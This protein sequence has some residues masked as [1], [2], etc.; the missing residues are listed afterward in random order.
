[1]NCGDP[2]LTLI[3]PLKSPELLN[4]ILFDLGNV[5]LDIDFDRTISAFRSLGATDFHVDLDGNPQIFDDLETGKIESNDFIDFWM[6]KLPDATPEQIVDAWN[7][8]LIGIH[9]STMSLL[10]NLRQRYDL[11]IYSNTNGVHIDWVRHY[12]YENFDMEDWEPQ[13]FKNAH[14]SHELGFRKPNEAGFL[15]ILQLNQLKASETLFIDDHL[16][17]V[18]TA[19][20]LGFQTIHKPASITL[21]QSIQLNKII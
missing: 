9:P 4:N 17:N 5:I 19:M 6:K 13:L 12:L 21:L 14:Y 1:M 20:R 11:F 10:Q 2:G 16:D 8:L 7:A 18:R 3:I 15:K